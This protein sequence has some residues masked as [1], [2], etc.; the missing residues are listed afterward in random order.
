VSRHKYPRIGSIS[1][2]QKA[3]CSCCSYPAVN[4]IDIQEDHMRGNDEVM[5]VCDAHLIIARS[6]DWKMLYRDFNEER[7]RRRE[8]H[9]GRG[10]GDE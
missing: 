7:W 6:G 4:R 3:L 1:A 5:Q 2:P 9:A 10:K 8:F